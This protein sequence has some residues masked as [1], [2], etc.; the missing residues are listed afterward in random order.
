MKS[1][2]FTFLL[3]L[4]AHISVGQQVKVYPVKER[5]HKITLSIPKGFQYVYIT[6]GEG[7][8]NIDQY[9]YPDSSIIYL[10]DEKG[11]S[12]NYSNIVKQ[13]GSLGKLLGFQAEKNDTLTLCGQDSNCLFWKSKFLG[14]YLT[15]GYLKVPEREKHIYDDALESLRIIY[16]NKKKRIVK[17]DELPIINCGNF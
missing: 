16:Y 8:S 12:L 9:T 4:L 2:V 1:I 10:T 14:N 13:E 3:S 6:G 15:I 11:G 5:N 17:K 7:R